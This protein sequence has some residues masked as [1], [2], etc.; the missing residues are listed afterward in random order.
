MSIQH[1][2]NRRPCLPSCNGVT[3]A[4]ECGYAELERVLWSLAIAEMTKGRR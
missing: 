4:P 1:I 2:P 3:H